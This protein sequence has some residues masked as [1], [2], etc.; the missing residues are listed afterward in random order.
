MAQNNNSKNPLLK[1]LITL[2]LLILLLQVPISQISELTHDR[3]TTK[4]IAL[5]ELRRVVGEAQIVTTPTL[6]LSLASFKPENELNTPAEEL[7]HIHMSLIPKNLMVRTILKSE[8]RYR[9][10]Y[11]LPY[12]VAKVHMEGHFELPYDSEI[13]MEERNNWK[14]RRDVAANFHM[15]LDNRRALRQEIHAVIGEE[16]TTLQLV[17]DGENR[18]SIELSATIFLNEKK[19]IPFA[20]DLEIA[21]TG[22]LRFAALA[23]N[24]TVKILSDWNSL[25]YVGAYLP[26]EKSETTD[27]S[28]ATWQI[29]GSSQGA[30]YTLQQQT[31]I[32]Q[33]QKE[34][35]FG[36]DFITPLDVHRMVERAVKYEALV[37]VLAFLAF[38]LFEIAC[39][40]QIHGVQYLFLGAA[41][42]LFYL[43][44]LSIAELTG[45]S[46]AYLLAAG[47]VIAIMTC[48]SRVILERSQHSWIVASYFA[49]S[50]GFT[51]SLLTEQD[52]SLLFGS[53]GLTLILAAVMY[54][55]RKIDWFALE[56]GLRS[57]EPVNPEL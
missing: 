3:S 33:S 44:L 19:L 5:Q 7:R 43:L 17:E 8:L 15:A 53:L 42:V 22:S 45:F 30:A 47:I 6:I 49:T 37:V 18:K 29:P 25:S 2:L 40:T 55:T 41:L 57:T 51:Y 36:V 56:H 11:S 20:I 1:K 28:E 12:Y 34:N 26:I 54:F 52:Y 16:K 35:L 50:Y 14:I 32:N 13:S 48:Y 39:G 27:G 9:G 23:E 10:I 46:L 31:W 21:G 38:F 24:S 4:N